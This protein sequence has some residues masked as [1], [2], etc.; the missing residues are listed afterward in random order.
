LVVDVLPAFAPYE[1]VEGLALLRGDLW[2]NVDNDGGELENRFV[3]T[4]RFRDPFSR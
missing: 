3:N 2:V 4:G 1:K